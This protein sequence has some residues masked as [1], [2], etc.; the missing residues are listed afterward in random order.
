MIP[1]RI[2]DVIH[3]TTESR[4]LSHSLVTRQP[5]GVILSWI[6]SC[7]RYLSHVDRDFKLDPTNREIHLLPIC[8]I[9]R[10]YIG[11]LTCLSCV[12]SADRKKYSRHLTFCIETGTYPIPSV[13]RP[14][15]VTRTIRYGISCDCFDKLS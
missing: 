10:K 2:L 12:D 14:C 13:T 15:D 8:P 6:V 1:H 4:I 5:I 3:G 9:S 7:V 11:L